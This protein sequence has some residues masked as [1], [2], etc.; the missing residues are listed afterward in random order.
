MSNASIFLAMSHNMIL[1]GNELQELKHK[2]NK[3]L[4]ISEAI[5]FSI[6]DFK[7]VS[8]EKWTTAGREQA[9]VSVN[10]PLC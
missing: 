3:L 10:G 2:N 8:E 6:T 5:S 7:A 9:R 1:L 4:Q